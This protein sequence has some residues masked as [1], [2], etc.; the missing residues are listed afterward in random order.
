[1]AISFVS[2]FMSA[3]GRLF[4]TTE[5]SLVAQGRIQDLQNVLW[6]EWRNSQDEEYKQQL[7]R[8]I[9]GASVNWETRWTGRPLALEVEEA[10]RQACQTTLLAQNTWAEALRA[11]AE[12]Q[13]QPDA[14]DQLIADLQNN[15]WVNRFVARHT[16]VTLG[17]EAVESLV[18]LP[19]IKRILSERPPFGCYAVLKL[20]LRH[21]CSPV[22]LTGCCALAAWS[23][24]GPTG[25]I[26]LASCLLFTMVVLL[27][28]K[29]D[30]SGRGKQS[31]F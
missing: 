13:Q 19:Q 25:R 28:A 21:V 6:R 5:T 2:K 3:M 26:Y 29:V 17:G 7:D 12:K 1:V 11:L 23:V 10:L 31:L 20:K 8:L 27:V 4:T 16:L 22:S 14:P 30:N 15:N 18:A 24:A 9:A